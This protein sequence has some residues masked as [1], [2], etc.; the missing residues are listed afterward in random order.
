MVVSVLGGPLKY[1]RNVTTGGNHWISLVLV[2]T[3]S[4]RMGTG[5]QI[6]IKTSDGS[7]QW[8]ESTT[9]V[10]YAS[11]SDPRVH[12]GLGS[13][14]SIKD[15]ELCWPSGIKQVLHNVKVDQVL[16]VEEPK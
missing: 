15:L 16:K 12:F 13:S 6:H 3:K 10:G 7:E 4:N 5:T 11:S 1:F 8:N 9:A 2:G 14:T